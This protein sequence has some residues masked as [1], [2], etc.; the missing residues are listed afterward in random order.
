MGDAIITHSSTIC[1]IDTS[2]V[3]RSARETLWHSFVTLLGPPGPS[4]L[5]IFVLMHGQQGG[6]RLLRGGYT[7]ASISY[8]RSLLC[9]LRGSPPVETSVSAGR[10]SSVRI[11]I[12]DK[13]FAALFWRR[14][15]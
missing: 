4:L 6:Y 15:S 12:C 10:V 5:L 13:P 14:A 11:E 7:D 3:R 9:L 2:A 1:E 8:F